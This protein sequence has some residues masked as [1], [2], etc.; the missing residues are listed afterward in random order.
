MLV[1]FI[2]N[3]NLSSLTAEIG[4]YLTKQNKT[5]NSSRMNEINSSVK[6]YLYFIYIHKAGHTG[7]CL[8]VCKYCAVVSLHHLANQR[9]NDSSEIVGTY[10]MSK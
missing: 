9:F 10:C 4:R 1:K 6:M 2:S 5:F 3:T 7:T 8:S